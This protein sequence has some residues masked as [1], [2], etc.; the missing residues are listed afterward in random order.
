MKRIV[1]LGLSILLSF[2]MIGCS[3]NPNSK[4]DRIDENNL[5]GSYYSEEYSQGDS[6]ARM[7][8][9]IDGNDV[10][11]TSFSGVSYIGTLDKTK[12]TME[13]NDEQGK[14]EYKIL[15]NKLVMT[16][17]DT[18]FS[19]SKG[20]P[21][22]TKDSSSKSNQSSSESSTK[23]DKN[24]GTVPDGAINIVDEGEYSVG[25]NAEI[26]A[27]AYYLILTSVVPDDE[28]D[29]IPDDDTIVYYTVYESDETESDSEFI[30]YGELGKA[31][32]VNLEE[33][34]KLEINDYAYNETWQVS[35]MTLQQ[36]QSYKN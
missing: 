17:D 23:S 34:G 18:T 8:L 15:G 24:T 33:G 22:K 28:S 9:E 5:N 6:S 12:K 21:P 35:L 26:P 7:L 30:D 32:R 3:S 20:N 27:G 14:Y 19:F 16:N 25:A 13:F 36:Y 29:T 31:F 10:L 1:I 11:V 4:T 2:T